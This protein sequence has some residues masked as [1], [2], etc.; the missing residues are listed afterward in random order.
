MFLFL[1]FWDILM[2]VVHFDQIHHTFSPLH[3]FLYHLP[4]FSPSEI[5]IFS[6]NSLSPLS[7][8]TQT[9]LI[10]LF[11]KILTMQS[12]GDVDTDRFKVK[13]KE[14]GCDLVCNLVGGVLGK[15]A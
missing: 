9:S 14:Y 8:P 7:T 1:L 12:N 5:Y 4:P 13:N 3:F 10:V 15:H 11:L 6:I 2:F